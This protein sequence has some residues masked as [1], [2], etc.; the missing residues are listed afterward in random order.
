MNLSRRA[1]L[2]VGAAVILAAAS[3]GTGVLVADVVPIPGI[4]STA[5]EQSGEQD[6]SGEK[7]QSG[8][9]EDQ[10]GDKKGQSGDKKGEHEDSDGPKASA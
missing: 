7:E 6:G 2:L 4:H 5:S 3:L 10:S 8:D 9:K 1:L